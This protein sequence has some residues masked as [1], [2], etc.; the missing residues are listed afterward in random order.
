[1]NHKITNMQTIQNLGTKIYTVMPSPVCQVQQTDQAHKI[2]K[3]RRQEL[4]NSMSSSSPCP[5]S[6]A[7]P[8]LS[9]A[10]EERGILQND[11]FY[12][13]CMIIP[14]SIDP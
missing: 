11:V 10:A 9:F 14:K 5:L 12:I 8:N 7:I 2:F 13:S 6:D 4:P 1:M 3:R